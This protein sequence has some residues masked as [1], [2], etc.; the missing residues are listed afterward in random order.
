M[1]EKFTHE[2][3]VAN[4]ALQRALRRRT[5]GGMRAPSS[6]ARDLERQNAHDPRSVLEKLTAAGLSKEDIEG[7]GRFK[8]SSE[9]RDRNLAKN[10]QGAITRRRRGTGATYKIDPAAQG[11]SD[12]QTYTASSRRRRSNLQKVGDYITHIHL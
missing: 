10:Q 7:L 8:R 6:R 4:S 11:K 3:G 5:T 2:T 12:S 9:G 1:S